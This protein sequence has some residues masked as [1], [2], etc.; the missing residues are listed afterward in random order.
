MTQ[1]CI[2][3]VINI[4]E[5]LADVDTFHVPSSVIDWLDELIG[6]PPADGRASPAGTLPPDPDRMNGRRAGWAGKAIAAFRVATGTDEEDALGDLLAD[7]RHW[8][9]RNG[10]DFD[11]AEVRAQ[12]HYDAETAGEPQFIGQISVILTADSKADA[13]QRLR[14]LA[15]Q[16]QDHESDIEFADCNG[17]IDDY[18]EIEAECAASITVAPV[19]ALLIRFDGYEIAPCR[20]IEE[21]DSP[22]KFYFEQCEPAE[23]DVW[24][25]Y[26]HIPGQGVETIGDFL[27]RE[28]AEEIYTR[29]TGEPYTAEP[30]KTGGQP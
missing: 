3:T 7:L 28:H 27:T 14:A 16:L 18:S 6:Q 11:A 17:D 26:G 22:G 10:Y 23:A 9:D 30:G 20:K 12:C 21:P 8:A 19:P 25:L 24:T 15:R 13:A 1:L 5:Q 4:R 2:P 29:I